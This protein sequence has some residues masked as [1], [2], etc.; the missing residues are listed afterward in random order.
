MEP[1]IQQISTWMSSLSSQL[2]SHKGKSGGSGAG[3]ALAHGES[4]SNPYPSR[5]PSAPFT[6]NFGFSTL[7]PYNVPF[8]MI[9]PGRETPIRRKD[10]DHSWLDTLALWLEC[11][12]PHIK[13]AALI[14]LQPTLNQAQRFITPYHLAL[15]FWSP[16]IHFSPFSFVLL[17][18]Y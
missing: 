11:S 17:M 7:S 18:G 5:M 2:I 15:S 4:G 9:W 6:L 14:D 1:M 16:C 10:L 8:Q 12:D 3:F 13:A